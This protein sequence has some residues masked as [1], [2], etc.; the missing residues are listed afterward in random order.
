MKVLFLLFSLLI[1]NQC[2]FSQSVG[3]LTSTPDPSA[4]LDIQTRTKGLLIPRMNSTNR[5]DIMNPADGL[6]IYN[7]ETE[8]FWY[9]QGLTWYELNAGVFEHYNGVV[10]NAG[11]STDDFVFGFDS[12]PVNGNNYSESMI[13]FDKSKN[14]FRAGNVFV[15]SSWNPSEVGTSSIALGTNTKAKG[16][17]S[18]SIG[19]ETEAL[20]TSSFATGRSTIAFGDYSTTLGDGTEANGEQSTALGVIT[21]ANGDKSIAMGFATDADAYLSTVIGQYNIGGGDGTHWVG[22]DPVFEIGIG[23][24]IGARENA[25]TVL[26]DGTVKLKDYEFP[27]QDGNNGEV[28]VTDGSGALTWQSITSGNSCP[29]D[30]APF[31]AHTCIDLVANT[32]TTYSAALDDCHSKGERLPHFDEFYNATQELS[33]PSSSSWNWLRDVFLNTNGSLTRNAYIART[34]DLLNFSY[35]PVSGSNYEYRC[36]FDK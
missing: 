33:L 31:N 17:S 15:S 19:R 5:D 18:I 25:M 16:T 24:N 10:R 32:A 2:L 20:G 13:F 11:S 36:V 4:A 28:L 9:S 22:T 23:A 14:A 29:A 30:M 12:L 7:T 1:F 34:S 26:K 21:N 27:N 8:S 35:A 6:L 3:I